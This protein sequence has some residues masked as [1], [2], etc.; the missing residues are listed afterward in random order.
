MGGEGEAW[1]VLLVP[2]WLGGRAW[3]RQRNEVVAMSTSNV[4]TMV[5]WPLSSSVASVAYHHNEI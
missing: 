2:G 4:Y 1:G 3:E 5:L